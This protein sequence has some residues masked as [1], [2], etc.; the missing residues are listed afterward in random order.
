MESI[1]AA[2][3][4]QGL[5]QQQRVSQLNALAITQ[6]RSLV[7][8]GSMKQLASPRSLRKISP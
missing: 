2:L 1:N 6:M 8:I 5:D 4:Q 3:I 7:G